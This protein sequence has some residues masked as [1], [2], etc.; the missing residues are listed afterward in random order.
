MFIVDPKTS[1]K[2]MSRFNLNINFVISLLD[3]LEFLLK[4]S[5]YID[6]TYF[7]LLKLDW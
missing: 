6:Y 2:V 1:H 7:I 5:A 3:L 4:L